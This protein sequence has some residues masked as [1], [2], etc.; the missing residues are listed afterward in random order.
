MWPPIS[1]SSLGT[2]SLASAW[3]G[4]VLSAL[5]Q[6]FSR[7]RRD[8]FRPGTTATALREQRYR[9]S[10]PTAEELRTDFATKKL[11]YRGRHSIA[12]LALDGATLTHEMVVVRKSLQT[13]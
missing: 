7:Y 11:S 8:R 9:S 6:E 12:D 5:L 3:V 2:G 4:L 1:N 10:G 13:R